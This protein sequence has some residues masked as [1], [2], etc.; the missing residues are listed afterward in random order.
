MDPKENYAGPSAAGFEEDDPQI[1]GALGA[2]LIAE[3]FAKKV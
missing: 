1:N 2:A 3:A